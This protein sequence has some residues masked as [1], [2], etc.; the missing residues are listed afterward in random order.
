M[1]VGGHHVADDFVDELV[2]LQR[3]EPGE[4]LRDDQDREMPAAIGGTPSSVWR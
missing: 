3:A 1:N 2:A 4:A